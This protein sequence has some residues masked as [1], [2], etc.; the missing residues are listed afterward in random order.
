MFG[1]IMA[2]QNFVPSSGFFDSKWVGLEHFKFMVQLPDFRNVLWNTFFIAMMKIAAGL[3]LPV[4][5]AILLN[6]V[7]KQWYKRF[8]QVVI[9]APYFLSWVILGGI[10]FQLLSIDGIVNQFLGLFGVEPILF[11]GKPSIFPYVLVASDTWKNMGFNTIVFLAA[12]TNVDP[13]L[14]EAGAIDGAN[15]WKQIWNI[16]LPGM[17]PIIIL[18]ATLSLGDILNAGF[19]QVLMLYGPA[20]YKTGDIIDTY[21]YRIGLINGQYSF[22]AAVGL[23]KSMVS[24]VMVSLSYYLAYRLANYRIF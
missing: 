6:E 23:F 21:V 24:L 5:I 16:T 4:T 14:H 15:R 8:I 22:A 1:I 7:M 3:L 2:F 12:I 9:Y 17:F 13:T 18:V 10:L 20:L 19:E 11:L